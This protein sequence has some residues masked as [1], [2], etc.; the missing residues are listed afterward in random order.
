MKTSF[1]TNLL[2]IGMIILTSTG[3]MQGA[4][5][6]FDLGDVLIETRYL[7]TLWNIGPMK[8]AYYASTLNNPF[9][10]HKKL[11]DFLDSIQARNPDQIPVKDAH[12]NILPQLMCD[13]LNGAR[14]GEQILAY[15]DKNA[16]SFINRAEEDLVRSLIRMIFTPEIFVQTRYLVKEGVNFARECKELGYKLYILSNWDPDSFI[17]LQK[18]IPD[19]FDLFDG[20]VI[21]GNVGISKPESAIYHYLL[22]AYNLDPNDSIFIDDQPDNIVAAQQIGIDG[23]VYTKKSGPLANFNSIRAKLQQ[24]EQ[25]KNLAVPVQ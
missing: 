25:S 5:I 14:T 23:I 12:G 19:F 3:L 21:S 22:D 13:W 6:I 11:F 16:G 15:V 17:L 20:I 10:C 2:A 7:A 1:R 9:K 8:M 24:W 18:E 4:N